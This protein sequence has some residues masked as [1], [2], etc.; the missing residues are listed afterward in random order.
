[1]GAMPGFRRL[2]DRVLLVSIRA[3]VMGAM[4]GMSV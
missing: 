4:S 2:L 1:M 3:P